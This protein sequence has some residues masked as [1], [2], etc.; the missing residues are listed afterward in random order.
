MDVLAACGRNIADCITRKLGAVR[1]KLP[2]LR[3][4][5]H[6]SSQEAEQHRQNVRILAQIEASLRSLQS[7][8]DALTL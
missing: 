7:M 1:S 6:W 8:M 4:G 2:A 3:A 5:P